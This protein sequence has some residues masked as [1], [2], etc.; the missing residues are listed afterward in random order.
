MNISD[1]QI[2]ETL[3]QAGTT[4][5]ATLER[6]EAIE[7]ILEQLAL[8]VPYDSASVQLLHKDYLEIVG[9]RA[10]PGQR[11]GRQRDQRR[12]VITNGPAPGR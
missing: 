1:Y 5:A 4:V 11:R 3:C 9:G 6:E 8:V 12:S 10:G 7:R 2:A